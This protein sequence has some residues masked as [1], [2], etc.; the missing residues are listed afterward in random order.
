MCN[1][2]TIGGEM[3]ISAEAFLGESCGSLPN[4]YNKTNVVYL[5]AGR[6]ALYCALLSIVARG[7]RKEA[8]LP[9]YCCSAVK[10]PFIHLGFHLHYYAMGK[11]LEHPLLP[12]QN[13][14]SGTT[15]L[16]IN[17]FGRKNRPVID[18]LSSA[19]GDFYIIEDNV[20]ASL[21]SGICYGDYVINS[22][23]KFLPQP[24]GALLA[25]DWP[26]PT[27]LQPP[28]ED[29]L[30]RVLIGKILRQNRGD[31]RLFLKLFAEAETILEE[32]PQPRLLS[33]LS[34]FMMER[35]D[36]A[37]VAAKRIDNYECLLN[38]LEGDS[39]LKNLCRPLFRTLET[40]EVP[41]G[42]P[43]TVP[44]VYRNHLREYLKQQGIYCPVHWLLPYTLDPFFADDITLSCSILTLPI[45]QR[46]DDS[47]LQYMATHLRLFFDTCMH[48]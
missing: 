11:R 27:R 10:T 36:L 5:D 15:F 18:W 43:V 39:L 41:L 34:R 20:Q 46:L 16:F 26:L 31:A 44:A 42:L 38:M 19:E 25:S 37:A 29:Y 21:N 30:S 35:T 8:W 9:V 32:C 22:Y 48:S 47:S 7:G 12:D 13:R 45:D 4:P 40:G 6:S 14:L 1:S 3:G 23:R 33:S 17:Y 2:H 24:D 28:R